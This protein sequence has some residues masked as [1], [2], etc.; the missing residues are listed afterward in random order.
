[1]PGLPDRNVSSGYTLIEMLVVLLL[2][3]LTAALAAP[4]LRP[5]ASSGTELS[6][7]LERARWIAV[8]RGEVVYLR[9]D[10]DGKWRIEAGEA[11]LR[12]DPIGSGTIGYTAATAT[13][14]RITPVGSCAP[15]VHTAAQGSGVTVRVLSCDVSALSPGPNR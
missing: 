7:L 8:E 10:P 11:A 12:Q 13:T 4:S 1:M 2:L 15:D 3:G 5:P 9:I 6:R 14:L